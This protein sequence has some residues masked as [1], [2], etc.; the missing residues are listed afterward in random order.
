MTL[1]L[2][3][4]AD[5]TIR[6]RNG[7]TP[8]DLALDNGRLD[9]AMFLLECME[10]G[11]SQDHIALTR[12]E[13]VSQDFPSDVA[14]PLFGRDEGTSTQEEKV[15][16]LHTAS[17]E[18]DLETVRGLLDGGADVNERDASYRTP[19]LCASTV[20]SAE[21]AKSL[22]KYGADVNLRERAGWAPLHMASYYGHLDFVHLL[23]GQAGQGADVN[24]KTV[25]HWTALHLASYFGYFEI[26]KALLDGVANVHV[27]NDEGRT[28]TEVASRA[29]RRGIVQ[30]LAASCT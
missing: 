2:E 27:Q 20:G 6:D 17:M 13:A 5:L 10:C 21:V 11:G 18:G 4:G 24:A 16:S 3:S 8:L 19:L 23:L 29:G 26:V 28:P 12:L 25:G 30:L 22:I 14:Q 15:I 9:V 1:L 7:K